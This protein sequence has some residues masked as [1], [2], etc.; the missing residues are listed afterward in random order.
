MVLKADIFHS[1]RNA[2][3]HCAA[4]AQPLIDPRRITGIVVATI[5]GHLHLRIFPEGGAEVRM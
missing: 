4:C 2:I 5:Q 1:S 3:D